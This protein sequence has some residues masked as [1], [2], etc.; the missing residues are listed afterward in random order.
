MATAPIGP[1]FQ[2][3]REPGLRPLLPSLA[4]GEKLQPPINDSALPPIAPDHSH[5]LRSS[6]TGEKRKRDEVFNESAQPLHN[7]ERPSDHRG[8]HDDLPKDTREQGF[9]WRA[10]GSVGLARFKPYALE[11]AWR[12]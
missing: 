11:P 4:P 3:R 9:Y 8:L 5:Y 6:L 1:V 10:D 12:P 2:P 7:R